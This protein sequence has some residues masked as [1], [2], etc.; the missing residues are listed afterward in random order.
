MIDLLLFIT[1]MIVAAGVGL[2]HT[3][4]AK[5]DLKADLMPVDIA[6]NLMCA[7][8]PKVASLSYNNLPLQN[9]PVYNCTSG[10]V[11]PFKWK[12]LEH[13]YECLLKNP[14][15]NMLWYPHKTPMKNN[16]YHDRISRVLFHWIPAYCIDSFLYIARFK[17]INL[18][19]IMSKMTKAIEALEY[20]SNREWTW[21]T[22]NVSVLFDELSYG[23]QSLYN[24]SF[25]QF[26]DWD[27]YF[28]NYGL[29]AREFVMKS[30]PNTLP[31]CRKK[32]KK[33]Y[34]VNQI[35]NII[36]VIIFYFLLSLLWK[37]IP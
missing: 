16:Y 32:I 24:F 34:V 22:N 30:D 17:P 28:E 2:L 27:T 4:H 6:I 8:A 37:C 26:D 10:S 14:F 15:E 13:H 20:F 18:V 31:V 1:G 11:L 29:G 12:Q 21:G 9:I 36:F 35:V 25:K 33:L 23:D 3:I 5:R 19:K 7:L